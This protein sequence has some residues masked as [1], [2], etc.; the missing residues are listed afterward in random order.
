MSHCVVLNHVPFESVALLGDV[1][2][3]RGLSMETVEVPS[4]GLSLGLADH[5]GLMVVMGGPISVYE[6]EEYPFLL[7]ELELL[8]HRL[9]RKLPTLGICLG[10]QLIAAA[11]GARVYPGKQK[12]IGWSRLTLTDAGSKGPLA[13]IAEH[14]VLHWH[15]DTFDLP[16]GA[17][18]LASTNVTPHQAFR[19]G[20]HAWALQ[21]HL[22]VQAPLLETWY[23]GN[24]LELARWGK[25][26]VPQLRQQGL[27]NAP[28]LKDAAE[29]CFHRILDEMVGASP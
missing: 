22:E 20:T 3:A 26:T 8:R 27:E 14:S 28:R 21:F 16:A 10:A 17:E 1:F 2:L 25:I 15:G 19:I 24:A 11:A 6:T 13:E 4:A 5:A 29:R 12:E 23:V 7:E 18:L 9:A